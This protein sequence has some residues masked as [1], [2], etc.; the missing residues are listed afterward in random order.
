MKLIKK[1]IIYCVTLMIA[2]IILVFASR[3]RGNDSMMMGMG[4]GLAAVSLLKAV[5]FF[6]LSRRP[7]K[8][9]EYEL[10]QNEERLIFIVTRS[11][12]ATF[13]ITTIVE[14]LIIVAMMIVGQETVA[15]ILCCAVALQVLCYLVMYFIYNKK[16]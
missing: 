7:E 5:Q 4:V 11:G 1:K 15:F 6:R 9:K 8:M 2:G 3:L 13:L 16:Y 14:Y 10:M 12:Y